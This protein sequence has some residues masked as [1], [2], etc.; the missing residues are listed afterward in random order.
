M[1]RIYYSLQSFERFLH[2]T[3]T[4][5]KKRAMKNIVVNLSQDFFN[6]NFTFKKYDE[7]YLIS[8]M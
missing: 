4:D 5:L 7:K 1:F 8:Y 3:V 2:Y 6:T